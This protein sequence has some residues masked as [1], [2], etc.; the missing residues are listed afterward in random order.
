M[1]AFAALRRHRRLPKPSTLVEWAARVGY[2]ARG[3]VYLSAGLLTLPTLARDPRIRMVAAAEGVVRPTKALGCTRIV[4]RNGIQIGF[5]PR[6]TS[7]TITR[8]TA[9]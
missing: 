2:G 1:P 4:S 3:F 6:F 8:I 9:I 7:L 5:I